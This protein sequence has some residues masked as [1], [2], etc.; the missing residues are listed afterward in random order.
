MRTQHVTWWSAGVETLSAQAFEE[1]QWVCNSEERRRSE[2][3][4]FARDGRS[5]LAAHG[6]LRFALSAASQLC[7]PDQWRFI[8][9]T[10]GRPELEAGVGGAWRFNLSH[11]A[12]RVT[13][14]VC[15]EVDC[16][17]D[18]EPLGRSISSPE[19]AA[20]CLA[21]SEQR[22]M[23]ELADAERK[24][25]FVRLWTLKE[26]LAKGVGMGLRLPFNELE[27]ALRPYPV[28][29]AAPAQAA[30]PWWLAQHVTDDGHVESLALRVDPVCAV[31]VSRLEWQGSRSV[32]CRSAP[33]AA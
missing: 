17:V 12:S 13:C 19:M 22:G 15:L 29:L 8:T 14:V 21:P 3:F 4:I 2:R 6:L 32:Q 10:H 31:E 26:A 7:E 16:G 33:L 1:L 28:V 24:A 30:G 9:G 11:C 25:E 23:K 18:V 20:Y 27:F 5:Y